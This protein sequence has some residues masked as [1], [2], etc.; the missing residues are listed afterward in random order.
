MSEMIE[1]VAKILARRRILENAVRDNRQL[2]EDFIQQAIKFAYEQY[3]PHAIC[4]IQ[5]MREPTFDML[6]AGIKCDEGMEGKYQ[7]MI[8]AALKD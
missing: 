3:I 7:S 8:D 1:K 5:S 4:A 2:T 6:K